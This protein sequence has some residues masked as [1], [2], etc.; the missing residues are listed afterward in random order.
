VAVPAHLT[1]CSPKLATWIAE[2]LRVE[3]AVLDGEICRLD[4]DGQPEFSG[5]A[6]PE[7]GNAAYRPTSFINRIF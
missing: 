2:H 4:E 1:G 6:L 7:G 5:S 3:K